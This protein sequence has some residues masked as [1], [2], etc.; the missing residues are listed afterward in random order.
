MEIV[1]EMGMNLSDL[2]GTGSFEV[3]SEGNWV[4]TEDVR[5]WVVGQGGMT[6]G[7]GRHGG[8][9]EPGGLSGGAG[10]HSRTEIE[11][12]ARAK[13]QFGQAPPAGVPRPAYLSAGPGRR[14]GAGESKRL[15]ITLGGSRKGGFDEARKKRTQPPANSSRCASKCRLS[16]EWGR[17]GCGE[18]ARRGTT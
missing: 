3:A 16:A 17:G 4:T 8:H 11:T 6:F 2:L 14:V 13:S 15:P 1:D 10:A 9:D 12:V 5:V 7:S 18:S